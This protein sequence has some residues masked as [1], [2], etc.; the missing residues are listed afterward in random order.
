MRLALVPIDEMWNKAAHEKYSL[1]FGCWFDQ[2][3]KCNE[4][5]RH[6][7]C[8]YDRENLGYKA[9]VTVSTIY[10]DWIY[11]WA[12]FDKEMVVALVLSVTITIVHMWKLKVGR[13][14]AHFQLLSSPGMAHVCQAVNT[15][16]SLLRKCIDLIVGALALY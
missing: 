16:E 1:Y 6:R 13:Q 5:E 4:Y 9:Q 14:R 2:K 7:D 10:T 8:F 12:G 3:I 11:F 15:Q